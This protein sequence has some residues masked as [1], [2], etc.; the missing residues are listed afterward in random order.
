MRIRGTSTKE[1]EKAGEETDGLIENTSKLYSKIKALTA[2]GGKEGIS[3]LGDDGRYL[4]T[5]QILT[6]IADRWEEITK[7]G[8][9]SALLELIAGE[10]LASY[11][12]KHIYKHTSNCRNS[13]KLCFHNSPERRL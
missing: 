3:I 7:A 2:V 10:C 9:D 6:K 5:Y 11:I 12:W 1:L 13:L 4:S 8:N